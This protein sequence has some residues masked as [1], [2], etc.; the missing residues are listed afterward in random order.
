MLLS[1]VSLVAKPKNGKPKD[2]VEKKTYRRTQNDT[3]VSC[4]LCQK[5]VSQFDMK[6]T[7]AL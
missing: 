6:E 3:E 4:Q 7:C 5:E 2:I 1:S